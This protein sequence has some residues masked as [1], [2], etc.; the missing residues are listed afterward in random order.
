[1]K[2]NIRLS[3][4]LWYSREEIDSEITKS[5]RIINQLGLTWADWAVNGWNRPDDDV[6]DAL[7]LTS[8]EQGK[9]LKLDE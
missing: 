9:L 8:E 2:E 5:R 4:G 7:E 3:D 1:M 6:R